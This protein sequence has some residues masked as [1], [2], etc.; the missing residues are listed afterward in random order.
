MDLS[1]SS[2]LGETSRGLGETSRG[3]GET[4]RV[5]EDYR[6]HLERLLTVTT[7]DGEEEAE[8]DRDTM[9]N[10][11]DCE[12]IENKPK[13]EVSDTVRLQNG[14]LAKPSDIEGQ[15]KES[16]GSPVSVTASKDSFDLGSPPNGLATD[17]DSG[18]SVS[19]GAK[20]YADS[21]WFTNP[22]H[23]AFGKGD[24]LPTN[25][26]SMPHGTSHAAK[27]S[28]KAERSTMSSHSTSSMDDLVRQYFPFTL[29][30]SYSANPTDSSSLTKSAAA[31]SAQST[32]S[33]L[34]AHRPVR[35]AA[36]ICK[37]KRSKS[38]R[39]TRPGSATSTG[40]SASKGS[41][42]SSRSLDHLFL[43]NAESPT[44][45]ECALCIYR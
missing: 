11:H 20:P 39:H 16:N 18:V 35:P 13:P 9:R 3:L 12:N 30:A 28:S 24:C 32:P 31:M 43:F 2:R 37:P 41:A 45:G 34:S 25:H 17:S 44:A 26:T 1:A 36:P 15:G 21:A 23:L 40:S 27:Y 6:R 8:L 29:G 7:E 14:V 10:N 19:G 5:T 4:S 42:R 38:P 33:Q 22:V